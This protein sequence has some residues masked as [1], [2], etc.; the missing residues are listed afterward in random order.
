MWRAAAY[1]R[2]IDQQVS[3]LPKLDIS[4]STGHIPVHFLNYLM[5]FGTYLN[6]NQVC[7]PAIYDIQNHWQEIHLYQ[8]KRFT[9]FA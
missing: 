7:S 4:P 5:H 8:K 1:F 3:V 9:N 6:F 2:Q